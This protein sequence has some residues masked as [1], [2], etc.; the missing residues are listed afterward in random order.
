MAF[1]L[2]SVPAILFA[3]AA[4]VLGEKHTVTFENN[5]GYG[6]P[7]LIQGPKVLSTGEPYTSDGPLYSVIAYLQTGDC[8]YDGIGCSLVE[9]SLINPTCPGCGSSSDI[10]LI[11]PLAYSVPVDFTYYGGCDGLGAT[12]SS[13]DCE[14]AFFDPDDNEVQVACQDDDV[15]LKITFCP[16]GTT[17]FHT[18]A[19]PATTS[20]STEK[21]RLAHISRRIP[22]VQRT[23]LDF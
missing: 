18:T 11:P 2:L 14:T 21:E 1:S 7:R 3:L 10:S 8:G 23:A 22:L 4:C 12:C 20:T 19:L 15:N 5:C 17:G 6:T 9:T 16:N 13:A